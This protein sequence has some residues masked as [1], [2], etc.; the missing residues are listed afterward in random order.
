[1]DLPQNLHQTHEKGAAPV[2][3]ARG[4]SRVA[5]IVLKLSCAAV[6]LIAILVSPATGLPASTAYS[7]YGLPFADWV[8][9]YLSAAFKSQ[10]EGDYF[11]EVIREYDL[12]EVRFIVQLVYIENTCGRQFLEDIWPVVQRDC[13]RQCEFWSSQGYPI[14]WGKDIVFMAPAV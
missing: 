2:G 13:K 8:Y 12:E 7:L 14:V 4:H 1:M 11:I 5:K 3:S 6:A 10:S 9:V